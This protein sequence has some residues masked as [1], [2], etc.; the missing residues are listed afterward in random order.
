[1]VFCAELLERFIREA[2][3]ASALNHPNIVTIYEIGEAE[4]RHFITM[5]LGRRTNASVTLQANHIVASTPSNFRSLVS[6][7]EC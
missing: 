7:S 2:R 6:F 3:A 5:E 4:G 1:V